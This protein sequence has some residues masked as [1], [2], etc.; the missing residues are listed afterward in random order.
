MYGAEHYASVGGIIDYNAVDDEQYIIN[1]GDI[2]A[3]QDALEGVRN[4]LYFTTQ[5]KLL[6][7]STKSRW[8]KSL[9]L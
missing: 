9:K 4:A 1:D 2:A 6:K 7:R 3:Y 8:S 5:M